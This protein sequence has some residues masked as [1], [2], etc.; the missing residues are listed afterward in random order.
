MV[1]NNDGQPE[2]LEG[3]RVL[4]EV[5]AVAGTPPAVITKSTD[6]PTE[7]AVTDALNGLATIYLS[8]TDTGITLGNYYYHVR[9]TFADATVQEVVPYNLF[10]VGL[11]GVADSPISPFTNTVKVDHN[12]SLPDQLAYVTPGGSP[13]ENAQVR[14][15]YKSDY[16]AGSLNTPVGISLTDARGR[17]VNPILVLPGFDYVVQFFKPNEWGPDTTTITA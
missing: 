8:P 17:W 9:V 12:W 14:L 10:V 5:F 4:F 6:D 3:A 1:V 7:I 13:I 16:D 2:S 11:G 15:Y